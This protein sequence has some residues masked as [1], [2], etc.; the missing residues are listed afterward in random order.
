M[1][2]TANY[3]GIMVGIP[4]SLLKSF[5]I[6]ILKFIIRYKVLCVPTKKQHVPKTGKKKKC[7]EELLSC[8]QVKEISGMGVTLSQREGCIGQVL[9]VTLHNKPL[10]RN[11]DGP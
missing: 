10:H 9:S 4:E 8:T 3:S 1:H 2:V 5:K 7:A 11:T 6:F